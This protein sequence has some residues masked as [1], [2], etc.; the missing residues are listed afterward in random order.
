MK[1][2]T[3]P[4]VLFALLCLGLLCWIAFS[5]PWLPATVA[6]HFG[7]NGQADGWMSRS[8]YLVFLSVLTL[9]LPLFIVGLTYFS[10]FLPDWMINLPRKEYWLSGAQRPETFDWIT[11][12]SLWLGCL[13]VGMLG[14]AHYL[15][16][17]ANQRVPAG[18]PAASF[19]VVMGGFLAGV[20]IWS[21]VL[22]R[23][24]RRLP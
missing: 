4:A 20:A 19:A 6:S 5:G 9:A 14:A 23:H 18:L 10:R 12:H 13:V 7:L 17:Q 8:A 22:W 2:T 16:I 21:L 11:A 15:T 24:F 3:L 1:K